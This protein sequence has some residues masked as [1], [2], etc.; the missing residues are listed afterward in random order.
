MARYRSRAGTG[1]C[2][3]TWARTSGLAVDSAQGNMT[4]ASLR[5]LILAIALR[6]AVSSAPVMTWLISGRAS[7]SSW[8]RWLASVVRS[9]DSRPRSRC[10][11]LFMASASSIAASSGSISLCSS[12]IASI[13]ARPTGL[14]V[15]LARTGGHMAVSSAVWWKRSWS[16]NTAQRAQTAV[17][18]ARVASRP[19]R[20]RRNASCWACIRVQSELRLRP[21][22]AGS[23]IWVVPP[24]AAG[25]GSVG[26][27]AGD[28]DDLAD[29][30]RLADHGEHEVGDAGARDGQAAAEVLP[31]RGPVAAGERLVSQS[32]RPDDG[33]VQAAVA[34]D[35]FH[36]RE[37]GI[38]LAEH[39]PGEPAEQVPHKEPV[40]R[41]VLGRVWAAGRGHGADRRGAD[42][43]DAP[44]SCCLHRR[45]D[46]PD[47]LRDDPDVGFRPQPKAGEHRAGSGDRS[48]Q[49]I[50]VRGREVGGDGAHLPGQPVRVP[51]DCCDVVAVGDGLLEQLPADT[52]GRSEDRELH[53]LLLSVWFVTGDPSQRKR[54]SPHRA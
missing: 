19:S 53:L 6:I 10:S 47:A 50:R 37:I 32:R 33:P 25:R 54:H 21:V 42:G 7:A 29:R 23:V 51:H 5:P 43:D 15:S 38:A 16:R 17:R 24:A 35:V 46:G 40:A 22:V 12:S 20:S 36:H 1:S 3:R 49:H 14:P 44:D 4:A 8:A 18:P 30:A 13:R 28:A 2:A 26:L 39:G 34:K 48:V 45:H 41:V 52:T 27:L 11:S 31:G 9:W